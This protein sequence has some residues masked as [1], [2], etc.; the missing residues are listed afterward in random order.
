MWAGVDYY[1]FLHRLA[2]R[3]LK[4]HLYWKMHWHESANFRLFRLRTVV[5]PLGFHVCDTIPF[6][7]HARL[8]KGVIDVCSALAVDNARKRFDQLLWRIVVLT[9]ITTRH[10]RLLSWCVQLIFNS[11]DCATHDET[12]LSARDLNDRRPNEA[13]SLCFDASPINITVFTRMRFSL[14]NQCQR[15]CWLHREVFTS[16]EKSLI[17]KRSA[18]FCWRLICH[19]P[20][21][22]PNVTQRERRAGMFHP[23]LNEIIGPFNRWWYPLYQ[24]RREG[25]SRQNRSQSLPFH[26]RSND[27]SIC[28]AALSRR[29][30]VEKNIDHGEERNR[31]SDFSLS[32]SS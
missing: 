16:K 29:E 19:K 3:Q 23:V 28:F 14:P 8:L 11:F 25:D 32:L 7:P 5:L 10:G 17:V 18:H 9:A 20:L 26:P 27:R 31:L 12:S 22:C 2:Y 6:G 24:A 13:R 15:S 4:R 30:H 21:S 1:Q